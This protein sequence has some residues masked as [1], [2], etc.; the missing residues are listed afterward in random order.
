MKVFI[1]TFILCG[2][3]SVLAGPAV[4]GKVVSLNCAK[5]ECKFSEEMGPSQSHEYRGFC[6]E[7][8]PAE[9]TMHCHPVKGM[10][11]T[12]PTAVGDY[13]SCLCTNWDTKRQYA[14]IDLDC[15]D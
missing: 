15:E 14:S 11:C 2:A 7:E 6:A 3:L 8:N 9:F 12:A 10:T 13:R 5:G 4:A 1:S